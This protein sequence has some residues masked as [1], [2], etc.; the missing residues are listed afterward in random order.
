VVPA[1]CGDT[2]RG[3][4]ADIRRLVDVEYRAM[5]TVLVVSN[6]SDHGKGMTHLVPYKCLSVTMG[7]CRW[8]M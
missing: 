8:A 7:R 5:V 2:D 3:T 4:V 6:V 1:N